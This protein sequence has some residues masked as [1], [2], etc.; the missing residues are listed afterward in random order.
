MTITLNQLRLPIAI[1]LVTVFTAHLL[2]Y[3]IYG[4]YLSRF[5]DQGAIHA[6]KVWHLWQP[7]CLIALCAGWVIMTSVVRRNYD[8]GSLIISGV[9]AAILVSVGVLSNCCWCWD[10]PTS[11]RLFIQPTTRKPLVS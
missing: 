9:G 3:P 6:L 10:A 1:A 7:V 8:G 11:E 5:G 2:R 4:D